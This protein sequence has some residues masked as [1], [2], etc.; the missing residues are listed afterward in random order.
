M[1]LNYAALKQKHNNQFWPK[2]SIPAY[3]QKAVGNYFNV[4]PAEA[5]I[6]SVSP[7]IRAL[8]LCGLFGAAF[9]CKPTADPFLEKAPRYRKQEASGK[10]L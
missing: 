7:K 6:P 1:S 2:K 10:A 8:G 5:G 4:W 9:S 3:C